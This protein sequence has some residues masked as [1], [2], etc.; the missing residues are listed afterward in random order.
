M[1][2]YF[3]GTLVVYKILE[4]TTDWDGFVCV[5]GCF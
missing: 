2:L 1:A 4:K 5:S 3:I